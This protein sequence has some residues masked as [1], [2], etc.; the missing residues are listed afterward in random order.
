MS[1][2]L[3]DPMEFWGSFNPTVGRCPDGHWRLLARVTAEGNVSRLRLADIVLD[4]TRLVGV[5]R[6]GVALAPD[7][8]WER[9][10]GRGGVEDPRA[11]WVDQLGL[12]VLTYTAQGHNGG[13]AALAIS[14]DFQ[15]WRRLG[16]VHFAYLPALAHDIN[17]F[18]NKDVVMFPEPVAGPD[19]QA[20]FAFLHRPMW[21]P[22]LGLP[23]GVE[24]PRHGIWVSFVPVRKVAEDI[25]N[26]VYFGGHRPVALPRYPYENFKI[27]AGPP[28]IRVPEGWLLIHH[29]VSQHVTE[30][31]LP[32]LDYAAG[33]MILDAEDVSR[34]LYRTA[35]PLLAPETQ[36][37]QAGIDRHIVFPTALAEIGGRCYL[38]YGVADRHVGVAELR[39]EARPD[40]PW[41]AVAS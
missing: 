16:P 40:S 12:F 28:P 2:D 26:L 14:E 13:R 37:E 24:D 23:A 25:S 6:R 21:D 10:G 4:G 20:A 41:E 7:E 35:E 8:A 33:A 38:F 27:G 29:G 32:R 17:M 15:H 11:T 5:R 19:G 39:A 18:P 36:L 1:P 3:D 30:A 31:P 34:V 9:N 22:A